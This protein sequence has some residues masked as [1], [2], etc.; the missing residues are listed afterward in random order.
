MGAVCAVGHDVASFAASLRA[1]AVGIGPIVNI[2]T[3]RLAI[4][5]AGEVRGL[6]MAAHFPAKR[7][8]VLDSTAQLALIAPRPARGQ[9]GLGHGSAPDGAVVLAAAIGQ[10]TFDF[11]YEQLYGQE[12]SRVHPFTIPKIMPNAPASQVSIEFGLRG[13]CYSVGSGPGWSMWP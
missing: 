5:I 11:A 6:E 4:R 7:L 10:G 13:P 1:G 2:P 8:A 3:E 9:A 12:V